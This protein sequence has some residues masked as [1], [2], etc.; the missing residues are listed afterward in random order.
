M[1][2]AR[3]IVGEKLAACANIL[4]PCRSV[5]RWHGQVEETQEVPLLIKTTASAYPQ[6]EA[7][8]VELH[9]YDVPEIIAL[10]LQTGLAAYLTWVEEQTLSSP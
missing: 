10:P 7:R 5:Y 2:I 8:L 6:L 9:P 1:N 4:A 3:T